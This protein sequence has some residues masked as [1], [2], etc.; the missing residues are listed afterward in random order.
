MESV[1]SCDWSGSGVEDRPITDTLWVAR[2]PAHA[3]FAHKSTKL[4]NMER[5][6]Q[7]ARTESFQKSLSALF[8]EHI[9]VPLL[10]IASNARGQLGGS[11][12]GSLSGDS[13]GAAS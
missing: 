12:G 3:C 4:I 9:T 11:R 8:L 2:S 13:G 10:L 5:P 1:W 7:Y 6:L